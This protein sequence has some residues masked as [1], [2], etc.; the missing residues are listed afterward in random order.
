MVAVCP[1]KISDE[2]NTVGVKELPVV[3][4]ALHYN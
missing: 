1:L 4:T 3:I 2:K